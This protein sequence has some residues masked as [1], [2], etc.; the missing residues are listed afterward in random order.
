MLKIGNNVFENCLI[1]LVIEDRYFVMENSNNPLISVFFLKDGKPI[2]EIKE[3]TPVDNPFT[4]V[5]KTS[6][7][8]ITVAAKES[9]RFIYKIRPASE[10]SI[11]FGNIVGDNLSVKINDRQIIVNTNIFERNMISNLPVGLTVKLNGSISMGSQLPPE[12]LW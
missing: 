11:V 7:G 12:L 5:S 1:P 9:N 10:T 3:N 2:F 8:I 6:A 4:L